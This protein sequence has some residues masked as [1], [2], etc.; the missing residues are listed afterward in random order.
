MSISTLDGTRR[1]LRHVTFPI[2]FLLSLVAAVALPG[3]LGAHGTPAQQSNVLGRQEWVELRAGEERIRVLAK[4]DTGAESSSI[5]IDLARQLK[6]DLEDADKIRIKS[7]L[8]EEQRPV[9]DLQL[10]LAGKTIPTRVTVND[11]SGLSSPMLIG[12]RDLDGF[13]V[14]ITREQLTAPGSSSPAQVLRHTPA[15]PHSGWVMLASVPLA[16]AIVVGMR[17]LV[18]V[19]TFGVFAPILLAIAFLQSGIAS[20]LAMLGVMLAAGVG[21]QLLIQRFRLPRIA[22]LAVLVAAVVLVLLAMQELSSV[23]ALQATWVTA[24]PIVVMASIIE[25]FWLCWEQENLGPALKMAAWT[26]AVAVLTTLL[27]GTSF[28]SGLAERIPVAVALGGALLSV[29]RRPR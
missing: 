22:R 25:R 27:L 2:L 7:S 9:V 29:K 13:L 14:D 12:A 3:T 15:K 8:G 18:G 1:L 21:I 11:R 5:D 10:R 24:F 26:I 23:F 17:T 19:S 6:I 16:A 28:V 20:G 4:V